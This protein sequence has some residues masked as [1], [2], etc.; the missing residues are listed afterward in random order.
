MSITIPGARRSMRLALRSAAALFMTTTIGAA[1]LAQDTPPPPTP[2]DVVQTCLERMH[3]ISVGAADAMHEQTVAG[4]ER[5]GA[6][7]DDGAT[8]RRIL[9]SA[10]ATKNLCA[11]TAHAAQQALN[12]EAQR[13]AA[14]LRRLDAPPLAFDTIAEGRRRAGHAVGDALTACTRHINHALA[15]ALGAPN[16]DAQPQPASL[17]AAAA[18]LE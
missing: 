14:I 4:V 8:A 13:C 15:R 11:R 17:G 5:L 7:A 1:A 12:T 10:D 16:D 9:R 3:A 2:Q 18:P 6:L